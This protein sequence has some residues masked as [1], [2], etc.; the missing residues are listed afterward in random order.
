M[1]QGLSTT[2]PDPWCQSPKSNWRAG[3]TLSP[4]CA[5]FKNYFRPWVRDVDSLSQTWKQVNDLIHGFFSQTS[6]CALWFFLGLQRVTSHQNSNTDK[7]LQL[8]SSSASPSQA[9]GCRWREKGFL[10]PY[11]H[12]YQSNY[13]MSKHNSQEKQKGKVFSLIIQ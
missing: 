8:N 6:F 5:A 7:H 10:H 12:Y 3:K 1:C 13:C 11:T 4:L 9:K 2:L